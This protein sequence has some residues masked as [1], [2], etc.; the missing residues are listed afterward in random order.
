MMM[1]KQNG[2]KLWGM[3]MLCVAISWPSAGIAQDKKKEE[4]P[5]WNAF[6]EFSRA[7]KLVQYGGYSRALKHYKRA[8]AVAPQTYPIAHFN[9][10]ELYKAR[11]NC[12]DAVLHYQIY[13]RVG[14]DQEAVKFAG[15]GLREC[16]AKHPDWAKFSLSVKSRYAKKGDDPLDAQLTLHGYTFPLGQSAS[17]EDFVLP[18]HL[19]SDSE[20]FEIARRKSTG[21]PAT[22]DRSR[23]EYVGLVHVTDFVPYGFTLVALKGSPINKVIELEKQTFFGSAKVE[24]D[25]E[26]ARVTIT[27]LQI[28]KPDQKVEPISVT[29]PMQE[30]VKLPTGKYRLLVEMEGFE[31]WVR[32]VYVTRDGSAVVSVSLSRALPPEIR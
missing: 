12:A 19:P 20:D 3:M 8:L 32:N 10:G 16:L 11:N 22:K 1:M 30:M 5:T 25:R 2:L 24:V 6:D 13:E 26:G 27:P 28:D 15:E 14:R 7:N 21:R 23:T 31:P 29:S 4:P 18:E 17:F 9:L